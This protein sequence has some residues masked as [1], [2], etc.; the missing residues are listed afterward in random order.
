MGPSLQVAKDNINWKVTFE[1]VECNTDKR[2]SSNLSRK[3]NDK[4]TSDHIKRLQ[5]QFEFAF[6]PKYSILFRNV[7]EIFAER[8][9]YVDG[10]GLLPLLLLHHQPQLHGSRKARGH[11]KRKECRKIIPL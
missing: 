8:D 1:V 5:L 10:D 3:P 4:I 11:H 7:A 2:F 9:P 6:Y